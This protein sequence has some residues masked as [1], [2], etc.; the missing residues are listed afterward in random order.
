M[1]DK[2]KIKLFLDSD[3][4][5]LRLKGIH[6]LKEASDLSALELITG[7]LGD[8]SW[9]VRKLA[10]EA[11]VTFKNREKIFSFLIES[12][13]NEENAGL[14]NSASEVLELVGK[15]SI[16]Y[17]TR[18][19]EDDDHDL[20][21]FV[22]DILGNIGNEKAIPFLIKALSDSDENVKSAA[23]E[24]LGKIGNTAAVSSLLKVLAG[25]DLLVQFSALE[26]LFKTGKALPVST[27][28]P[29]LKNPLLR[30]V[31]FE[32]LGVSDDMAALPYLLDG[33]DDRSNSTRKS[34]L[35]NLVKLVE[36]MPL[37][38]NEAI[39]IIEK[40]KSA[41]VGTIIDFLCK[42]NEELATAAIKLLGWIKYKD[43]IKEMLVWSSKDHLIPHISAAL[44]GFGNDCQEELMNAYREADETTKAYI[45][46]ILGE[47]GNTNTI[48]LLI[49]ELKSDVGHIRQSSALSLGKIGDQRAFTHLIPLLD[50]EYSN[51]QDAAVIA[52][53]TLNHECS[54]DLLNLVGEGMT[55]T[56]TVYRFNCVKIL[57]N[58]GANGDLHLVLVALKDEDETIRKVALEAL[59]YFDEDEAASHI[60][61]ALSDEDREVRVAATKCLGKMRYAEGLNPIVAI[62]S[63][64]DIWVRSAAIRA[65]AEI[66]GKNA[67]TYLLPLLD[68]SLGLIVIV[69]LETLGNLEEDEF[70]PAMLRLTDHNDD[71]VIKAA[72]ESLSYSKNKTYLDKLIYLLDHNSW[73]VR[74]S[75]IKVLMA[76]DLKEMKKLLR[77]RLEMEEDSFV[78]S[79]LHEA[80]SVVA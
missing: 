11:M 75:A 4:K 38:E 52:L 17:L 51:V 65:V 69:T 29:H 33:L 27:I 72:V 28:V 68:D 36:K 10:V 57:L 55:S 56:S 23:A 24:N 50:D 48:H 47:I 21:K 80:L 20:R 5:E 14:R 16:D 61:L 78:I 39:S 37:C 30:K 71:K 1:V 70:V 7:A 41:Y 66:G 49:E 43:S 9:R 53:S 64:E 34:A 73:E 40:R 42:E 45:A 46:Y 8:D 74:A 31:A 12:L 63:D 22:V 6:F 76:K 59:S 25:N 62:L 3:D 13:R 15:E 54:D 18:L 26:A 44:L 35:V 67:A 60:V 19:I 79:L 58:L 77:E 32:V 2:E